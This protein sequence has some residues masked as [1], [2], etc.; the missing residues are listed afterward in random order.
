MLIVHKQESWGT[1]MH[2]Q[3][4]NNN[5]A[6]SVRIIKL[7]MINLTLKKIAKLSITFTF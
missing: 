3:K 2:I 6:N 5:I 1:V 7:I 4:A